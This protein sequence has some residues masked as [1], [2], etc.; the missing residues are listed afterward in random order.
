VKA[1]TICQPYAEM[2]LQGEKTTENRTWPTLYRGPLAIHAGKSRAW[3][4]AD[5]ERERPG[6]VFG[7]IVA[8]ATLV[9]CVRVEDLTDAQKTSDHHAHGPWCWLLAD[10]ERLTRPSYCR[11]FQGLWEWRG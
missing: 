8:T 6:M 9:G 11:G 10:V 7:A 5:D 1:L 3:L 2:I 4:E